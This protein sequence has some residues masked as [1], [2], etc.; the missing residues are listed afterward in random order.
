MTKISY[1]RYG[2]ITLRA[3][4]LVLSVLALSVPTAWTGEESTSGAASA[5]AHEGNAPRASPSWGSLGRHFYLTKEAVYDGSEALAACDAGFHMASLWEISDVSNLVYDTARGFTGD[6][7]G[8]GPPSYVTGWARTGYQVSGVATPG[9]GNCDA[10]SSTDP[11]KHGS[12]ALLSANWYGETRI[13]GTGWWTGMTSQCNMERRVW[14]VED[15]TPSWNVGSYYLTPNVHDGA[16]ALTACTNGYHMASIWEILDPSN[17]VYDTSLGFVQ[18]DSGQ[19]P[20][21]YQWA[22]GWI[23]TGYYTDYV[24]AT[25]GLAN[26]N[27]WTSDSPNHYG[28]FVDIHSDWSVARD[29][30]VWNAFSGQCS[31]TRPVWCVRPP[32][33]VYLPIMFKEF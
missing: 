21:T 19:G 15:Y 29:V 22:H 26:C 11:D 24:T 28:T 9:V 25:A 12:L 31:V 1:G 32:L 13:D 5:L 14:C 16:H 7:S 2:K 10:W 20:P 23:R 33:R 4:L 6:D 18:A 27:S 17:L 8:S 3:L 30:G